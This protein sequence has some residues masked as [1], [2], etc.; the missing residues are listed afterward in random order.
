MKNIIYHLK[1]FIIL[2]GYPFSDIEDKDLNAICNLGSR[3]TLVRDVE[4]IANDTRKKIKSI[5]EEANNVSLAVDEW[6]DR[7]MRRYLG[8]TA[9]TILHN[10]YRIFTLA[11]KPMNEEHCTANVI[12]KHLHQILNEYQ[13]A[14]KIKCAVTD[15]GG[16]VPSAFSDIPGDKFNLNIKRFPCICHIIN[17]YAKTFQKYLQNDLREFINVRNKFDSACFVAFLMTKNSTKRGIASFTEIRWCSL[18]NMLDDLKTLKNLIIEYNNLN[19]IIKIEDEFWTNLHYWHKMFKTFVYCIK[20]VEGNEFGLISRSLPCIRRI[21]KTLTS[22]PNRYSSVIIEI[23]RKM[24]KHWN[25]YQDQ[26]TPILHVCARLN[27]YIKHQKILTKN[28][29]EIADETIQMLLEGKIKKSEIEKE[30]SSDEDDF[31]FMRHDNEHDD[32][33]Q[34]YICS[35]NI[36]SGEKNLLQYWLNKIGSSWEPL[37]EIALD[38]LS[39]PSSSATAERQFSITGQSIGINRLK[40]SEEHVEDSTI[41]LLNPEISRHFIRSMIIK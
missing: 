25:Q 34:S 38:F 36:V 7:S 2:N 35:L 5:L 20:M 4:K 33:L 3:T 8:V 41:I 12:R 28:E 29:I 40:I 37:A 1:A 17:I 9:A 6:Q 27:P 23:N 10:N 18:F 24:E 32:L 26:W 21:Q 31:D 19:N 39:I 15:N 14:H 11:H 13:I 22:L 30:T 16:A